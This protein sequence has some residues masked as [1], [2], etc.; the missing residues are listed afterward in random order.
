MNTKG[1]TFAKAGVAAV[2]L[3]FMMMMMGGCPTEANPPADP[4][5]TGT[6]S[7][8][9]EPRVGEELTAE[10]G[11]LGGSGTFSYV[12]K[13]ADNATDAG[14][15]IAGAAGA[16]YTLDPA[17][18]GKYIKVTVSRAGYTGS[19]TSETAKGAILGEDD[20]APTINSV[21]VSAADDATSLYAGATL[22]F[23]AEV[24]VD[25]STDAYY[26][27]VTWSITT[28]GLASGT[29]ISATGLLSVAAGET[30]TSLEIK[31]VSKRNNSK[32]GTKSV[33]ITAPT[34]TQVTVAPATPSVAKGGN[35]QF[36]ASVTGTGN[37]AATVTW[38][39][40]ET[41]KHAETS[42]TTAGLLTVNSAETETT[43]TVRA[44]STVDTS[45][46]GEATVTVTN[47]PL[48][49]AVTSV[50]VTP[51]SA[52][53][54][55]GGTKQFTAEVI[56]T[57]GAATTVTWS[58]TGGTT[59]TSIS[60]TG[61]LT[62]ASTQATSSTLTVRATSTV[63]N[64]KSGT[65]TVTV[66]SIGYNNAQLGTYLQGKPSN[67]NTIASAYEIIIAPMEFTQEGPNNWN[68]ISDTISSKQKYVILDFSYC[69]IPDAELVGY[70]SSASA[71]G[72][73]FKSNQ[74]VIGLILPD[75]I[76][77]IGESAFLG[78][79]NLKTITIP[80]GVE[81]IGESAFRTCTGLEEI[82]IP[83]SVDSIGFYA[84]YNC[85]S[86]TEITITDG[87]ETIGERAF[88]SCTSL[89]EI[90]I[91]GSVTTIGACAFQGCTGLT[92][93]T[94][95]DGVETIGVSAFEGCT[96][97]E[98]IDI[99]STVTTIGQRA[100]YGC[101]N[102]EEI[103]I[104]AGVTTIDERTFQGCTSIE[105]LTIPSTVTTINAYAF[106]GL[107]SLASVTFEG[108]ITSQ[109]FGSYCFPGDLVDVYL[110]SYGEGPG[111]PGTY[112]REIPGTFPG[113][114]GTWTKQED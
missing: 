92:E 33:T 56:V 21:A 74:Y 2:A 22:Q 59:G 57:G 10:T 1:F 114:T 7:I 110:D 78:C 62:V 37:P 46:Y 101:A 107:S 63:D 47:T 54:A 86:L 82:T 26:Q 43:L 87:V 27:E 16:T 69:T 99:P 36:T 95:T 19:K 30:Q 49:P 72:N 15:A 113:T 109:N 38:S 64:T 102:I 96:V 61:F 77:T 11:A 93:I 70:S 51:A 98:G 94:I 106:Y 88:Q 4:P 8:S 9:G 48:P 104:P 60:T 84:F 108:T 75:T 81:T 25:G 105:E 53:V 34:V 85:T 18:E 52:T 103:T 45:K 79:Y 20:E 31:A 68:D 76:T 41:G 66:Q 39:I 29:A 71:F 24:E 50:T 44:T 6:V 42:I 55:P 17:D 91:P 90:T 3:S 23:S 40:I 32:N 111:G 12:W 67:S 73:I 35:Q 65:A 5:L 28:T 14:T 100:F 83:G 97:L 80:E 112:T 58:V 89:A 13:R